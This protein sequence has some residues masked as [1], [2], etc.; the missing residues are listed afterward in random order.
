M[1]KRETE[2]AAPQIEPLF[3]KHWPNLLLA[4]FKHFAAFCKNDKAIRINNDVVYCE[5]DNFSS[6]ISKV[7]KVY[8]L[9]FLQWDFWDWTC[10]L[11]A[12]LPL[13]CRVCAVAL[14]AALR[15]LWLLSFSLVFQFVGLL[16]FSLPSA[17]AAPLS[18]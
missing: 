12:N 2:G 3:Q 7:K 10:C 11:N 17:A 6:Y 16:V 13:L 15:S 1:S 9:C 14:R 4:I 18:L 8:I 5:T